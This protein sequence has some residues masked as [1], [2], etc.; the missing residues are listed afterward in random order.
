MK[1]G[2]KIIKIGKL[3]LKPSPITRDLCGPLFVDGALRRSRL[4]G[5]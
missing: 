3:E 5:R 1:T 2:W 4:E